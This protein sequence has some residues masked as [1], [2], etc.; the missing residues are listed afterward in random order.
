MVFVRL[1]YKHP[2]V[3]D[4]KSRA[5][6]DARLSTQGNFRMPKLRPPSDFKSAL[7]GAF[8][9]TMSS[10]ADMV[11]ILLDRRKLT[12]WFDTMTEFKAYVD[13]SGVGAELEEACYK[14]MVYGRL[15]DNV[16][17]L[18]DIQ[19]I[20]YKDR[21]ARIATIPKDKLEIPIREGHR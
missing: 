12:K 1:V 18:N 2:D 5:M 7:Q 21:S 9:F 8:A 3:I 14:P 10:L 15:L 13:A 4:I 6:N 20:L 11:S 19:E 17:I 16:K